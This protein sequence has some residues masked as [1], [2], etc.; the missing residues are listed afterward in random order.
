MHTGT[1]AVL[2]EAQAVPHLPTGVLQAVLPLR[3]EVPA[4]VPLTQ[5]DFS[6]ERAA[7]RR[8]VL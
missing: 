4:A 2:T 7:C 3:I 8:Q 1:Q 6:A 5:P